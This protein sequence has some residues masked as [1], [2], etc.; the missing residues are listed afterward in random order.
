MGGLGT[1]IFNTYWGE[2]G[3][4]GTYVAQ[5][6]LTDSTNIISTYNGKIIDYG[7]RVKNVD[8]T[9][10]VKECNVDPNIILSW[11]NS[12]NT[13][14]QGGIQIGVGDFIECVGWHKR[15]DEASLGSSNSFRIGRK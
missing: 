12:D 8:A 1:A 7:I 15:W 13:Y 4:A 3:N 9:N 5:K 10:L 14:F 2:L 11:K 6:A